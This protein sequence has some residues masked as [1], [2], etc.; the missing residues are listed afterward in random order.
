[1]T[2]A[3]FPT[4]E[5]L[6]P[7]LGIEDI[8]TLVVPKRRKSAFLLRIFKILGAEGGDS[9]QYTVF[10]CFTRLFQSSEQNALLDSALTAPS[11]LSARGCT[12]VVPDINP[13]FRQNLGSILPRE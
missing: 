13:M 7:P 1:V 9:E 5:I 10:G 2:E 6:S 11:A 4:A 3:A 12:L 8:C